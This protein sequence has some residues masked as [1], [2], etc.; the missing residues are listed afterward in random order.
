MK[1]DIIVRVIETMVKQRYAPMTVAEIG[2]QLDID[3]KKAV[4]D[5]LKTLKAEGIVNRVSRGGYIA[6]VGVKRAVGAI[7]LSAGGFGFMKPIGAKPAEE[8]FIPKRSTGGALDGDL[9]LIETGAGYRNCRTGRLPTG[10]VVCV[11]QR[12]NSRIA[13]TLRREGKRNVV[14]PDIIHCAT[15]I[16]VLGALPG[17]ARAGDKVIV[18]IEPRGRRLAG[19]IAEVLGRKGDPFLEQ[20]LVAARY[21]FSEEF[22]AQVKDELAGIDNRSM[23]G[24]EDFRGNLVVTIDPENARDFD[25]AVGLTLT[26]EG[27]YLLEVHIADVAR[28]V[29]R[30]SALDKEALKRTTTV[31]LPAMAVGMLPEVIS[32]NLASLVPGEDRFT[33]SAFLKFDKK[34]K[35]LSSRVT[36]GLIHSS[37][38]LTYQKA[39]DILDGAG[40]HRNQLAVMLGHM[41]VLGAKLRSRRMKG[42]ALELETPEIAI[43]TD[44][45]GQVVNIGPGKRLDTH[46]IIEEFMLAANNAMAGFYT[47]K[48]LPLIRRIHD[49]PNP[50]KLDKLSA[51]IRTLGFSLPRAPSRRDLQKLLDQARG[52]TFYHAVAISV[53][54]CF[55]H[56][57]YSSHAGGHYAL[58]ETNYMH[59]TSPIRRYPDLY[60][61][62]VLDEMLRGKR[63]KRTGSE[64]NEVAKWCSEAEIRAEEAEREATSLVALG[65]MEKFVGEVF[66]G[67]VS[68]ANWK[69]IWVE[70]EG[71]G[72]DGRVAVANMPP[73]NYAYE[74]EKRSLV[75]LHSGRKYRM[76]EKVRVKIIDVKPYSGVL[77]LELLKRR[78]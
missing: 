54:R 30:G 52:T 64:M 5:V 53:L 65:Y 2:A 17:E 16:Q 44:S 74:E 72:V 4:R 29:R 33:K 71:I 23:D 66:A 51:F 35:L 73:G 62:Q 18:K 14:Y 67:I 25:D 27:T 19:H 45:R 59:F 57:E 56:A 42:G 46:K 20:R 34:G 28:F 8:I 43:K 21:G 26:A 47:R 7:S 39:Q 61:H 50:D 10:T 77:E 75:D 38:R 69:G 70:L 31:Y 58:A 55:R 3:D 6:L 32:G 41:K 24:C 78:K 15:P 1:S 49:E 9:V 12:A 11:L 40:K 13:G 48:R 76:G 60:C 63:P 36:N 22:P 68:G 37:G